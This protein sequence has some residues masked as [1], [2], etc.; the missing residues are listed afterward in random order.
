MSKFATAGN[1]IGAYSF[2]VPSIRIAPVAITI[3]PPFTLI[4]IPP[5]VPTLIK[6]LAP[7]LTSSSNA[8]DAEG[9]P[10]PVE[11]TLTLV[12]FRYPV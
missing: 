3:S 6:V 10:I 11:V 8:I 9:P 5:Q 12:P 7:T 2:V 1:S 4:S